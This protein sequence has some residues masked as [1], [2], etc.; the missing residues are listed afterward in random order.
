MTPDYRF[1]QTYRNATGSAIRE[2]FKYMS[3]P[4]MISFAGGYPSPSLFDQ[5]GLDAAME[6][7]RGAAASD[8][9][10]Y[11]ATEGRP[12]LREAF[13]RLL[14]GRG[15]S[16]TADRLLI[17]SGSQQGFDMLVRALIEPGDMVIVTRPAYSAALQALRLAGA[18]LVTVEA[19][20]NGI[21]CDELERILSTS[22]QRPKMM[23]C[24]P[25]FGNPTGNS[26]TL[27]QRTQL[28]E[29]ALRYQFLLVEDDPYGELRFSGK[30]LATLTELAS[31]VPGAADWVVYLS[32]LS[33]IIAPGL[34][35]GVMLAPMDV[36]G[37]CMMTKQVSDL[38]TSPWMQLVAENYLES[39]ALE[40]NLPFIID[41]YKGRCATMAVMLQ[42][43]LGDCFE[44]AVP[45]GG[46]FIWG[47]W[48]G[49][50]DAADV[51]KQAIAANVV[52]VPGTSF[53]A[54][55]PDPRTLRLSFAMSS[56]QQIVDGVSRLRTAYDHHVE[57]TQ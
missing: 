41:A 25:T 55:K 36:R 29:L 19:D 23:Y 12:G 21:D 28:V 32:S 42:S 37:R 56:Q 40:R 31:H 57:S 46:M 16:T 4:D 18:R 54:D 50:V 51:F 34:R 49:K 47:E 11:G 8:V 14:K 22:G 45:E 3:Y 10:Q 17:T 13:C 33:K 30:P 26:F 20:M 35:I 53:Y 2:L 5:A 27:A 43:Q 44:F 52:Y 9:L 1:A 38:C 39:G 15:I 48:K 7:T 6:K 24:V